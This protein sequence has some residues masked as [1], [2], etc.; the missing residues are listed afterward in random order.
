MLQFLEHIQKCMQ[1]CGVSLC[2][3]T[4]HTYKPRLFFMHNQG[5]SLYLCNRSRLLTLCMSHKKT[6]VYQDATGT[7]GHIHMS[8]D[9]INHCYYWAHELPI[10]HLGAHWVT[11][12]IL[13]F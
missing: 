4:C 6:M 7:W 5:I 3:I 13:T 11:V 9:M 12:L 1:Y 2:N 8:L 10:Y